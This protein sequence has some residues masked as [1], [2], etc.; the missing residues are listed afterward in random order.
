MVYKKRFKIVL[1]QLLPGRLPQD[2]HPPVLPPD[3]YPLDID[4]LGHLPTGYLA[5][6]HLSLRF[7]FT[8]LLIASLLFYYHCHYFMNCYLFLLSLLF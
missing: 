6:R 3:I 2:S 1:W 8:H 4:H 7:T 5:F